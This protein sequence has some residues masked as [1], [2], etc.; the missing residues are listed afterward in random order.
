MVKAHYQHLVQRRLRWFV[1]IV[2]PADVR[3]VIGQTI[4]M[5]TTG[6]TDQ[7]QAAL[8]A[9]PIIK[10]FQRRIAFARQAGKRLETVTAEQLAERYREERETDPE[11]AEIT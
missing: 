7:H 6:C 4:F 3:K 2:V 9:V 1:R 8:S 11:R 5:K 10:A